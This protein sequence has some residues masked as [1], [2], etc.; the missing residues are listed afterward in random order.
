M[1]TDG[2]QKKPISII[3]ERMDNMANDATQETNNPA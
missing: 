2:I 1:A 3:Q